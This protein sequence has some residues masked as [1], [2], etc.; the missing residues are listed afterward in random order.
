MIRIQKA[1]AAGPGARPIEVV[2]RKGLGHP[3]SIC[4]ALAETIAVAL[5]R[6]YHSAFGFVPHFNI[7]KALLVA[8][9]AESAFGGGSIIEPARLVVGDRA[10][11]EVGGRQVP[12]AEIA[13]TAGRQW[14]RDHLPRW[15]PQRHV[16]WQIELRPGSAEL[17][18]VVGSG[19]ERPL[20]NDTSAAV[21]YAPLTATENVVLAAERYLNGHEFKQRFPATGE[22]V[23]ILAIR[24]GR[25]LS[26][27]VAM[28]LVGAGVPSE[29]AYFAAKRSIVA[30]LREFVAARWEDPTAVSVALNALDGAG[31]GVEGV[32]LTVTG[33]SA[34]SAD[35]GQVGRGN[36]P[37]GLIPC[38]RPATA[39]AVAGKNPIAHVGKIYA[40]LAERMA[41]DLHARIEPVEEAT[42][43]LCSR[44]GSPVDEPALCSAEVVLRG[45]VDLAEVEGLIRAVLE[46][47]L[48]SVSRL[49]EE[50]ARGEHPVC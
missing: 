41:S 24:D 6:E 13:E 21:G 12:V 42:V 20:A 32:Y 34:E 47:D 5:A 17:V 4:D 46:E 28:P 36:R 23:K 8:G 3:D 1:P 45:G 30:D 40:F 31:R 25:R 37:N 14:I 11:F 48:T 39:E 10:T 43:W 22:D 50:L 18:R 19:V 15:D 35:S 27:T 38:Q 16:A 7:D 29:Q 33:T 49:C 44:I 2:E 9:R 26:L